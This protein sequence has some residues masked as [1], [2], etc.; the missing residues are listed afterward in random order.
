MRFLVC[1]ISCVSLLLCAEE[2]I[3]SLSEHG[4]VRYI[5]DD[6][7]LLQIERLSPSD[8]VMYTHS[9]RYDESGKLVSESL[10]GDLGEVVYESDSVVRSP[11]G[12]EECEFDE[13]H[14]LVK[15]KINGVLCEYSYNANHEM[16]VLDD[17]PFFK[18]DENGN[19]IFVADYEYF[20]DDAHQLIRVVTPKHLIEYEY[21]PY[22]NR[23]SRT[24]DQK[25]E[26]FIYSGM[27]EIAILDSQGDLKQLCIPGISMNADVL[28]PIA[29]E[30]KE[31][32]FAP[33]H[34]YQ[35]KII[36]LINM[37]TK[38]IVQL[39][40]VD[41]F[42]RGIPDNLP[43][44]WVFL[45]KNYDFEAGLV[46]FGKRYY[47]PLLRAWMTKD[48]LGQS[49]DLY[50][51][52]LGNPLSYFDPDG[53]W[54]IA[55]PLLAWTGGAI[56]SPLWGPVALGTL[57]GVALGYASYKAVEW[58]KNNKTENDIFDEQLFQLM[59]RNK[60]GG[61][62]PDLP[63]N[64]SKDKNWKDVS[65]P[66]EK[67]A[68]HNTFKNKK[69]G[70]KIRLDNGKPGEKGHEQHDHYHRLNPNSKGKYDEYLDKNYNPVPRGSEDSHLY[71]PQW[72]WWE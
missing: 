21:D 7:H 16:V 42:G 41:P 36:K 12:F 47:S 49:N 54:A 68:G 43:T 35:G 34:D 8:E 67:A 65:H 57:G 64:P 50:E 69:T 56:T 13:N 11:F 71:P 70:E 63:T 38:E 26:Y 15:H 29:I 52:C 18:R 61:I 33:I 45:G 37:T 22:G 44:P 51:F 3:L 60:K 23:I 10:I 58:F 66:K 62:D 31:G 6:Q 55:V 20:Y 1:L 24:L 72:V 53:E 59:E 19:A 39:D 25:T 48:P 32:V 5:S 14:N 4:S 2:Q 46:Y 9:Y 28:R 17:M 30:T 27:N 40:D